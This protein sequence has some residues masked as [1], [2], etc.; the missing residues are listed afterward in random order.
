MRAAA[1]TILILS[2]LLLLPVLSAEEKSEVPASHATCVAH[3]EKALAAAKA[4]DYDAMIEACHAAI[5]EGQKI[6]QGGMSAVFPT[7]LPAGW[8]QGPIKKERM[9]MGAGGQSFSGIHVSR[10][11]THTESKLVVQV[12]IT[13]WAMYQA[14]MRAFLTMK[15]HQAPM[16]QAMGITFF[17]K[18]GRQCVQVKPPDGGATQ[19]MAFGGKRMMQVECSKGDLAKTKQIFDLFDLKKALPDAK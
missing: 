15:E 2:A 1:P 9:A 3:C 14:Q 19:V 5:D 6:K 17:D 7:T 16:L 4:A 13:E 11:F 10:T 18:D 12:L 8:T